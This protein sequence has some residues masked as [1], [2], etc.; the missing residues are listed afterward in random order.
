MVIRTNTRA[1]TTHNALRAA[2]VSTRR[3]AERLSSGFR[4]NSAADDAASLGV[5]E[6]KRAQ[7]EGLTMA[8]R[9]V[10]DGISMTQLAE[11]AMQRIND[12]LIRV[13]DLTVQMAND[14]YSIEDRGRIIYEIEWLL[15]EVN[16][17]ANISE[18]NGI[19]LLGG[20]IP[21]GVFGLSPAVPGSPNIT[22]PHIDNLNQLLGYIQGSI[23]NPSGV[24]QP[25]PGTPGTPI[26]GGAA[27]GNRTPVYRNWVA[28]NIPGLT[29]INIT[30][31][32]ANDMNRGALWNWILQEDAVPRWPSNWNLRYDAYEILSGFEFVYYNQINNFMT[33][34]NLVMQLFEPD[35]SPPGSFWENSFM[36]HF[37]YPDGTVRNRPALLAA[38]G[39]TPIE[40]YERN[41]A[42]VHNRTQIIDWINDNFSPAYDGATP[43]SQIGLYGPIDPYT[44]SP[45][46]LPGIVLH[47]DWQDRINA[48]DLYNETLVSNFMQAVAAPAGQYNIND[49]FIVDI[50]V[51]W[52]SIMNNLDMA[53]FE[54]DHLITTSMP[55]N[56]WDIHNRFN[57]I[58]FANMLSNHP[59]VGPLLAENY[60][61]LLS[62]LNASFPGSSSPFYNATNFANFINEAAPFGGVSSPFSQLFAGAGV[63]TATIR[64]N[65][66]FG[67]VAS[68]PGAFDMMVAS[69]GFS[70]GEVINDVGLSVHWIMQNPQAIVDANRAAL[71]QHIY[72]VTGDLPVPWERLPAYNTLA[73]INAFFNNSVFTNVELL[74][75]IL[76]GGILQ[77][78]SIGMNI[79]DWVAAS[80]PGHYLPGTYDDDGVYT[81][82]PYVPNI[83]YLPPPAAPGTTAP[84]LYNIFTIGEIDNMLTFLGL[85]GPDDIL[86][87][88]ELIRNAHKDYVVDWLE[89]NFPNSPVHP[90]G[91]PLHNWS[92][93]PDWVDRF[94]WPQPIS[95]NTFMTHDQVQAFISAQILQESRAW[96]TPPGAPPPM[97]PGVEGVMYTTSTGWHLIP[98]FPS[99]AF[100]DPDA[101]EFGFP[102]PN[103][104]AN[105]PIFFYRY[106][107]VYTP[108]EMFLSIDWQ[109]VETHLHPNHASH[110]TSDGPVDAFR[111]NRD[112][113]VNWI[114]EVL[115]GPLFRSDYLFDSRLINLMDMFDA[116]LEYGGYDAI[117]NWLNSER[118]DET[119]ISRHDFYPDP[120]EMV[121]QAGAN[122][123]EQIHL[124]FHAM[125]LPALG[126]SRFPGQLRQA[127]NADS[128]QEISRQINASLEN[129]DRGISRVV[130][131]RSDL[132][133]KMLRMEHAES[134][135]HISNENFNTAHSQIRDT[136][137]ANEAIN[138]LQ[139]SVIT[140]S[141]TMMMTQANIDKIRV[142]SVLLSSIPNTSVPR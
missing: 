34:P 97:G 95:G 84:N 70:P 55:F 100:G 96:N 79:S 32:E 83:I 98:G 108:E 89:S 26:P 24:R 63:S 57:Q 103:T 104:T 36:E 67:V 130:M 37:W 114:V 105:N 71:V 139:A 137:M 21:E 5:S 1:N 65:L 111:I 115:G 78:P 120:L 140:E 52:D 30:R 126:I 141:A 135:L 128:G 122:S 54:A 85:E 93:H 39:V 23:N 8:V 102:P 131:R 76:G 10:R 3:S 87:D 22:G 31:D 50:N 9:N 15:D 69:H 33:N 107:M 99:T 28:Q 138:R 38:D 109:S 117:V 75:G 66:G 17:I 91:H 123:Y 59:T 4:I 41:V 106:P 113:L 60:R 45:R 12:I 82:G 134:N 74:A 46:F 121:I 62:N 64:M 101:P 125:T 112:A 132:G 86:N 118:F 133:S 43:P 49:V 136:D 27:Y 25:W 88:W 129:M 73:G 40:L 18:F 48:T 13:R 72:E 77:N 42:N 19:A 116:D 53:T 142:V 11:G 16:Q 127:I 56:I 7:I 124:Q 51:G 119:F 58:M 44:G 92:M 2:D 29:N 20:V 110:M 35:P 90:Y 68:N 94:L 81:P 6:K 47:P 14:V 80:G 61:T